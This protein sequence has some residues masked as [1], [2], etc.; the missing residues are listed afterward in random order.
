MKQNT[1]LKFLIL[2]FFG[3]LVWGPQALSAADEAPN[4]RLTMFMGVDVSGSF[5]KSKYFEKSLDFLANYLYAHLNGLG[6]LE[7]PKVLFLGSL[8][9]R[10][11]DEAKSFFPIQTFEGKS[12]EEIR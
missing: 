12:V 6:G 7:V 1:R 4:P 10:K 2:I 8:G 3:F 5:L 11:K 9:G